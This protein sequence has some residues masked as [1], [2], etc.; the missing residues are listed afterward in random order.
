MVMKR[1][2][3][4]GIAVPD[5]LAAAK[6]FCQL[7]EIDDSA[8]QIIDARITGAHPMRYR[9]REIMAGNLLALVQA[10]NVEFE[11]IQHVDG[12]D[13]FHKEYLTQH[14][15]GIDHICLDVADYEMTTKRMA[16]MGGSVLT[17]GGE[18]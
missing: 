18:G 6:S 12:D 11:F 5:A 15:A 9:G 16:E 13:N 2:F 7:F 4:I 8:I 3:Q 1:V 14:G 10:A 17:E